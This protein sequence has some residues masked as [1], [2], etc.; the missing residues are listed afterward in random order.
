MADLLRHAREVMTE[1]GLEP[2]EPTHEVSPGSRV[3]HDLG[4]AGDDFGA[5]WLALSD[6]VPVQVLDGRCVPLELSHDAYR[7]SM[8]RSW[9]GQALTGLRRQYVSRI[10]CP[11]VTLAS[12]LPGTRPDPAGP[13]GNHD[14]RAWP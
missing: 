9:L 14:R 6:R 2:L 1:M 11:A 3:V 8:A 4:L 7:V 13:I 10:E 5:F 12:L